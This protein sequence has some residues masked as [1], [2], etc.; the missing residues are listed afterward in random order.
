MEENKQLKQRLRMICEL[1]DEGFDPDEPDV[2]Q[3]DTQAVNQAHRIAA[4]GEAPR[5]TKLSKGAGV[6][7]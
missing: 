4:G 7:T 2:Y 1:L 6:S 3:Y 5:E